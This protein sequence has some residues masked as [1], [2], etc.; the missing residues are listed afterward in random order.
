VA[1][2]LTSMY[3]AHT[4]PGN[5]RYAKM[6]SPFLYSNDDLG[7]AS[8]TVEYAQSIQIDMTESSYDTLIADITTIHNLPDVRRNSFN[9]YSEYVRKETK[10]ERIRKNNPSVALA[11]ER[12]KTILQLVESHYE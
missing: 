12:Y 3:Q 7:T 9:N 8:H 5:R 11:Y 4:S 10:E 2:I 6:K 1:D